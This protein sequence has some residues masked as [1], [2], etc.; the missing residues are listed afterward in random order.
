MS[1]VFR[2]SWLYQE[3]DPL[4]MLFFMDN[5]F[6]ACS[7]DRLSVI[8]YFCI[9]RVESEAVTVSAATESSHMMNSR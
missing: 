3:H 7:V 5:F 2:F 8:L 9:G 6:A 4:E 1:R